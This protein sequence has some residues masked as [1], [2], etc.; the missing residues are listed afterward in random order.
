MIKNPLFKGIEFTED[1]ELI[2]K[3]TPLAMEERDP[4][5]KVAATRMEI[6]SDVNYGSITKQLVAH[7]ENHQT[8]S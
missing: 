7:L 6:D 2:K 5:Q 1:P 4:K 8:L 3:W